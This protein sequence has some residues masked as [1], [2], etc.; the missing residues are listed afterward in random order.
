M[1][2]P[3]SDA[4]SARPDVLLELLHALRKDLERRG[5]KLP[6]TWTEEAIEDLRH[7]RLTGWYRPATE[8]GGEIGFYSVRPDRIFG[9][10]HVLPGPGAVDRSLEL[11][12]AIAT[13]PPCEVTPLNAGVSGLNA[14]DEERVA[15]VWAGE[16]RRAVTRREGLERTI[17]P[18]TPQDPGP[19][20]GKAERRGIAEVTDAALVDLD[21][22]GF[23]GTEDADLFARD[24]GEY[25]RMI[26][27]IL[28]GRLGRFLPEASCALVTPEGGL[29]AF[30]LTVEL[31]PRVALF[32]DVVVDP[33]LRRQGYGRHLMEWGLRALSALGH[34]SVRL[35]VTESNEAARQLYR[36]LGFHSYARSTI[37]RQ[38]PGLPAPQPQRA[39]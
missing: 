1:D 37:F 33:S 13:A 29:G 3:L 19:P 25:A 22:R 16:P 26:R 31:S 27:G 23:A 30:I 21:L 32:A 35:W 18:P 2:P 8:D 20:P 36:S 10:V 5:E 14:E 7:G 11:L 17:G 34:E 15:Q 38:A 39:R 9:H 24:T 6:S 12:H 4:R 28:D